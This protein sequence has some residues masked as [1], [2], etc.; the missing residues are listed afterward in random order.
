MNRL[1]ITLAALAVFLL[2]TGAASAHH[3]VAAEFGNAEQF[4]IEGVVE[5]LFWTDPPHPRAHPHHRRPA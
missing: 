2:G 1:L 4:E 5:R 3:S